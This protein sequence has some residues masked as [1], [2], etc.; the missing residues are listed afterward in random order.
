MTIAYWC[1]LIAA[2][3]PYPI[4]VFAKAKPGFDNHD[5]RGWL[6][7]LDGLRGRAYAAH[8]NSF[9]ALHFLPPQ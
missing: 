4:I 8:L 2:L 6:D 3:L 9:E 7:N 5:P 1:V